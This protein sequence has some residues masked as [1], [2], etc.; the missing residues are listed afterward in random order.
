MADGKRR[1]T[2]RELSTTGWEEM[3]RRVGRRVWVIRV[4]RRVYVKNTHTIGFSSCSVTSG[5][6][7]TSARLRAWV[8]VWLRQKSSYN[9]D[10]QVRFFVERSELLGDCD[11]VVDSL[12]R[13]LVNSR[14]KE[15]ESE[16]TADGPLVW[17]LVTGWEEDL[18]LH[19][20]STALIDVLSGM[21]VAASGDGRARLLLMTERAGGVV[22]GTEG[23][24]LFA[25]VLGAAWEGAGTDDAAVL[26]D[27]LEHH[28][29]GAF[30]S[31]LAVR[32]LAGE[33]EHVLATARGLMVAG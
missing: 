30:S 6:F 19:S 8:M 27:L 21:E 23:L 15:L 1:A 16:F 7:R 11:D 17:M 9:S 4:G 10:A 29:P 25:S 3:G 18:L 2:G 22:V 14:R 28:V 12:A 31:A 24:A 32:Q 33:V 5:W 13:E 20:S 26:L